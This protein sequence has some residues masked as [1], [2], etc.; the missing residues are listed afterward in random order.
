[1]YAYFDIDRTKELV[2]YAPTFRV[3]HSFKAYDIDFER[4]RANL[5]KRFGKE[6]VILVHLHPNVAN[7]E[8]GIDYDGTTVINSTF[9]PDTQELIAVSSILIGD[10]SS[11]NYDFSLKRLPVFRYASDLEEYRNDRDLYFPFDEYPYPC[12]QNNDELESLILNFDTD[13]YLEGLNGFFDKIGAVIRP[14]ASEK[15]VD[16]VVDY[17]SSKNIKD[18][19]EMHKDKF[20]Y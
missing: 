3:D 15:I 9:Y 16:L 6:Y 19:L 12:A 4:L 13:A 1:M 10:Y 5:Q 14:D 2:L 20:Y 17:L 18:F 11:V 7:I 8:G